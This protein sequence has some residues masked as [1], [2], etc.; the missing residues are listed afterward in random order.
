[1]LLGIDNSMMQ[2]RK[3]KDG[4]GRILNF[5]KPLVE[6]DKLIQET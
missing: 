1:M 5:E 2:G 6:L 3:T 4:Y